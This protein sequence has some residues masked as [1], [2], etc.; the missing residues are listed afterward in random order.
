MESL[1]D[2]TTMQHLYHRLMR[3]C[4]TKAI[5]GSIEW[6]AEHGV[7]TDSKGIHVTFDVHAEDVEMPDYLK[8]QFPEGM[9]IILQHQYENLKC[10]E[11]GFTVTLVFDGIQTDI[12]V[13]W[14]SIKSYVDEASEFAID[15]TAYFDETTPIKTYG[16]AILAADSVEDE[17]AD[18]EDKD[19]VV[20]LFP[21][22]ND[23]D[24]DDAR[25]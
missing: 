25:S 22:G 5:A 21:R 3:T 12:V 18:T 11:H 16:A 1:Y 14:A 8:E 13:A 23:Q 15:M 2:K 4:L 10:G 19:N 17:E 9:T 20:K 6:V 7:P 24:G